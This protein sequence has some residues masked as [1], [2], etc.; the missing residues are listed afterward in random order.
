LRIKH[1]INALMLASGL[2]WNNNVRGT[3]AQALEAVKMLTD[4]GFDVNSATETGETPLHGAA[5]PAL[6]RS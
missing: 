1:G 4:L 6:I 2:R 3:E 5:S